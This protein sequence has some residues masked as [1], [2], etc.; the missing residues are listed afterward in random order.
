MRALTRGE[1]ELSSRIAQSAAR[2]LT[3]PS[4]IRFDEK[5]L[6]YFAHF[7]L[8]LIFF[9]FVFR[10]RLVRLEA[11]GAKETEEAEGRDQKQGRSGIPAEPHTCTSL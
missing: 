5:I 3:E 1:Q 8:K 4:S 6:I 10:S 7:N 11:A 9:V 2:G